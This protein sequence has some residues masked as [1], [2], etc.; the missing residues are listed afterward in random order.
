MV[1][2]RDLKLRSLFSSEAG[3]SLWLC[4]QSLS[5]FPHWAKMVPSIFFYFL[6]AEKESSSVAADLSQSMKLDRR[7]LFCVA[8]HWDCF[9]SPSGCRVCAVPI[10]SLSCTPHTCKY[11]SYIE[12][13]PLT[14]FFGWDLWILNYSPSAR[15]FPLE[16][17]R[18]RCSNKSWFENYWIC[19]WSPVQFWKILCCKLLLHEFLFYF[20]MWIKTPCSIHE[21][22]C[23]AGPPAVFTSLCSVRPW[24]ISEQRLLESVVSPRGAISWAILL[25]C[26]KVASRKCE[27]FHSA[28]T[29]RW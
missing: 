20:L 21:V 15:L 24:W 19:K 7:P 14:A 17:F 11:F 16:I 4:A 8:Q 22:L 23:P 28:L 12:L 27:D 13:H 29:Q 26:W 3:V 25:K 18:K 6:E 10:W 2:R 1:C 5:Q 9:P